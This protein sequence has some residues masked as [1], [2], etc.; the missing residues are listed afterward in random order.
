[1]IMHKKALLI[2][3]LIIIASVCFIFSFKDNNEIIDMPHYIQRK[4]E[5][6]ISVNLFTKEETLTLNASIILLLS[7]GKDSVYSMNG[8]IESQHRNSKDVQT[9]RLLRNIYFHYKEIDR[10]NNVYKFENDYV[11]IDNYDNVSESIAK[12]M[13]MKLHYISDATDT[14][15]LTPYGKNGLIFSTLYYPAFI[16]FFEVS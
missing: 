16:C 5:A 14:I 4:C 2:I 10:N 3:I 6:N 11:D 7:H 9:F 12:I 1:M 15:V 13:L 8:T